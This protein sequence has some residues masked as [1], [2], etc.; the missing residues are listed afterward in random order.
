MEAL[1]MAH[2]RIPNEDEDEEEPIFTFDPAN[3][4]ASTIHVVTKTTAAVASTLTGQ[5]QTPPTSPSKFFN[6][7]GSYGVRNRQ[8]WAER[9]EG[10]RR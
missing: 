3:P 8:V 9:K 1:L 6:M 2:L 5:N 7:E 4:V 10:L